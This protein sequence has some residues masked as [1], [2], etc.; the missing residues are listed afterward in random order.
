MARK[1]NNTMTDA[2]MLVGG[3]VIGAGLALLFAPQ[4]GKRTRTEITRFGKTVGRKSDKA[5]REFTDNVVDFAD[6]VGDKAVGI[7]H[8]G[9]ELTKEG[10]KGILSAIEKG[11]DTLETQK[12]KLARMMG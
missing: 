8:S 3:S 1:I 9:K 4:S 5:V 10:R 12:R 2:L 11:Q 7:L 6:R